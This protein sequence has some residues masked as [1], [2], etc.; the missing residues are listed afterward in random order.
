MREVLVVDDQLQAVAL[1]LAGV[2]QRVERAQHPGG[3]AVGV[4]GDG[5]ALL[6]HLRG[7]ELARG[8]GAQR[9]QLAGVAQQHLAGLGHAQRARAH[10]QQLPHLRLE[11][12][13]ALRDGRLR[14]RQQL[15]GALEAAGL[16][17]RGQGFERGGVEQV[18]K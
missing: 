12:A 16:G 2:H 14:D 4:D 18:H 10:H 11:R 9:L 3:Q 5:Q 6:A 1:A 15:R 7:A 8:V 13:Q 17:Q